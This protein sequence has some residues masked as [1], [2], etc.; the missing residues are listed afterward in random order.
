MTS[1]RAQEIFFRNGKAKDLF[2]AARIAV[3]GGP[4]GVSRLKSLTLTGTSRIRAADATLADAHVEIRV[5]LPDRYLRIDSGAFGRRLTGYAGGAPLS[6]IETGGRRI[7]P[8]AKD[9]PSIVRAAQTELARFVLGG[10]VYVSQEVALKL[11]TRDTRLPI[12]GDADPLGIEAFSEDG[13]AV[14]LIVDG[15]SHLPMR[16]IY[17]DADKTVLTMSFLDRR[18]TG[19]IN[20]PYRI[21]TTAGDR[22]VD[23]LSFDDIAV[24]PPLSKAD[25]TTK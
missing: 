1:A 17:W 19:G 4:G 2:D 7:M 16:V 20:L 14:R 24:N 15:H 25:F 11:G 8:D 10:A 6:L 13:F 5:L 9:A 18:P 22:V 21:V 3:Y 12:P 23:Q